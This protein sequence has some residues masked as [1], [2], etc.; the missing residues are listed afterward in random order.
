MSSTLSTD[1]SPDRSGTNIPVHFDK[2]AIV[3]SGNPAEV[4]GVLYETA[5]YYKR[6]GKFQPLIENNAVLLRNGRMAVDS[7]NS[8]LFVS[9][10]AS[11]QAAEHTFLDPCPS[12]QAPSRREI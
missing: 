10:A 2:T 9:G 3:W 4:D 7:L 11:Y 5:R 8:V 6:T 1:E 12:T